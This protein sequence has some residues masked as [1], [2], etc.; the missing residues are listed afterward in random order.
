MNI[1][2]FARIKIL[3]YFVRSKEPFIIFWKIQWLYISGIFQ[4]SIKWLW[5]RLIFK[6]PTDSESRQNQSKRKFSKITVLDVA[7]GLRQNEINAKKIRENL[8]VSTVIN[9]KNTSLNC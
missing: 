7:Y 4:F 6:N 1:K 3:L 5:I 8:F 2:I 9:A